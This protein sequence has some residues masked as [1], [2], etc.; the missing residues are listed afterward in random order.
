MKKQTGGPAFP[1]HPSLRSSDGQHEAEGAT[2]RQLYAGMAMQGLLASGKV[3]TKAIADRAL[4][5][6]DALIKA[7]S[8]HE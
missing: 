5:Y 1:L 2:L 7:E 4:A 3:E 6:A 8:S